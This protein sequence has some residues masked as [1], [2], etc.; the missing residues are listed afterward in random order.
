MV[1]DGSQEFLHE[2]PRKNNDYPGYF[3]TWETNNPKKSAGD[4]VKENLE[5]K[6][7]RSIED[8]LLIAV[9]PDGYLKRV[10]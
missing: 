5:F 7:D 1:T 3:D 9:S 4:F 2:T 8:K 10:K 6:I